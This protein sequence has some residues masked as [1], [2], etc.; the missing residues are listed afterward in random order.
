MNYIDIIILIAFAWAA[1]RGITKGFIIMAASLLALIL[2]IWGAIRFSDFTSSLLIEKFHFETRYLSVIS[3]AL[4]F[5]VIV[6]C[7]QLLGR[8]F[9]KLVE[10]VALGLVNRIAGLIFSL[11]KTAF[12]VSILL[13]VLNEIDKNV[14]FIP[15]EHRQGSFFYEPLSKL[16]PTVFPNLD[17]ES[18]RNKSEE[19]GDKEYSL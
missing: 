8:L 12:I 1:Y 7:V 17:F 16:A 11:I 14:P 15:E 2:G 19:S 18:I 10:A 9:D 6:I 5:I 4:T 3:F 13:T